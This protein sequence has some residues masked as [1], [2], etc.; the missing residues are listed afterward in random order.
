MRCALKCYASS[1]VIQW[2][3]PGLCLADLRKEPRCINSTRWRCTSAW[4]FETGTGYCKELERLLVY[5]NKGT[6]LDL[7]ST[8]MRRL[9]VSA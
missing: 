2:Y 3:A 9:L 7:V 6:D 1:R 8:V 5:H 4:L